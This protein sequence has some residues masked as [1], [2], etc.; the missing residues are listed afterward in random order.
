MTIPVFA[1]ANPGA[2]SCLALFGIVAAEA[3]VAP[4]V[5]PGRP[6]TFDVDVFDAQLAKILK[7]GL[8]ARTRTQEE[9]AAVVVA[10]LRKMKAR[11]VVNVEEWVRSAEPGEIAQMVKFVGKIDPRKGIGPKKADDLLTKILFVTHQERATWKGL[12][13]KG[14]NEQ[15]KR[16]LLAWARSEFAQKP[17]NEA[18]KSLE[19]MKEPGIRDVV[20]R[21]LS[22]FRNIQGTI[23][24]IFINSLAMS[25]T[26]AHSNGIPVPVH[27]PEFVLLKRGLMKDSIREAIELKGIDGAYPEIYAM[28]GK[29]AHFQVAWRYARHIAMGAAI[30]YALTQVYPGLMT[31]LLPPNY[32]DP[33]NDSAFELGQKVL[34]YYSRLAM[35][36]DWDEMKEMIWPSKVIPATTAPAPAQPQVVQP[37][38]LPPDASAQ[39]ATDASLNADEPR[40]SQAASDYAPPTFDSAPEMPDDPM[41]S[42]LPAPSAAEPASGVSSSEPSSDILEF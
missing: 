31:S 42:E 10:T 16:V 22:R 38:V 27:A 3:P 35:L 41:I 12:A 26:A 25:I 21:R 8:T 2:R 40:S 30:A 19:L 20:N 36:Y 13:A 9:K 39:A 6:G 17:F 34:S 23:R 14:F 5:K 33:E 15:T 29:R 37:D 4:K 32:V 11:D 24:S 18:L 1:F 28:Y 7:E